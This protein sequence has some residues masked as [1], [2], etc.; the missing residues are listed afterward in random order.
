MTQ[1][2]YRFGAGEAE[3]R[4]DQK[5][6][7]GGK[8]AGLAEM[9][10]L[11]IPVPPGFTLSCDVSAYFNEHG[12][13]YPEGMAESV[14]SAL[15]RVSELTDM[16]F[17]STENPLLLSVRSGAPVSMPGMMDTVLNLGLNDKTVLALG[18]K[19]N[20]LRFAYDCYRRFVAM[21]GEVV[22][23]AKAASER[24][25]SPF[26]KILS[27]IDAALRVTSKNTI[28]SV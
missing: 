6:L 5:K 24:E 15:E 1:Y 10:L 21:Y 20:D 9:N 27:P 28:T 7:L 4:G 3:G 13:E 17:G 14:A 26:S 19:T 11:G 25:E 8:G 12:G 23:G 16:E 2:V 18:E 22:M